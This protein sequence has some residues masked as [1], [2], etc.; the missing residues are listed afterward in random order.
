MA[1]VA[2]LIGTSEYLDGFKPLKSAP[3]DVSALEKRLKNP[4]IFRS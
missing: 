2:L 3:Q 4:E 1:R